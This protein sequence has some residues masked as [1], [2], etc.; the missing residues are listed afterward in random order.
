MIKIYREKISAE[1]D[2]IEAEFKDMVLG[3]D[4]VVIESSTAEEMF[5][6]RSLPVITNNERVVS[7]EDI[8]PYLKELE[9]LMHD[10]QLFQGDYCYVDDDG[11][12]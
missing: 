7:G 1:A 3:Y 8:K 11:N 6:G 12:C 5:K 2:A 9:K 10:W 4:Q